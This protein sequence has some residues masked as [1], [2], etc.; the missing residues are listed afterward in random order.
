MIVYLV[1][2][3]GVH[4]VTPNSGH[5]SK[6]ELSFTTASCGSAT[7]MQ[8]CNDPIGALLWAGL[9]IGSSW[10]FATAPVVT[11]S[12]WLAVRTALSVVLV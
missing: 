9:R 11:H 7:K 5:G 1:Y 12:Q 8:P 4:R 3:K 2:I 6:A 10:W